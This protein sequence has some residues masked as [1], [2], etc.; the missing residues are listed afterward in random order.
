MTENPV[1]MLVDINQHIQTAHRLDDF[2]T[3]HS[4][5]YMSGLHAIRIL[6]VVVDDPKVR[7]WLVPQQYHLLVQL[8]LNGLLHVTARGWV[9]RQSVVTIRNNW[10]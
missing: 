8:T 10:F 7:L 1:S 5:K 9:L 3:S 4:A 2:A 6:M